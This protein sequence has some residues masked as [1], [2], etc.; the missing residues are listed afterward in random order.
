MS[1]K[2]EEIVEKLK[3]LTLLEASELVK[4]IEE[5]F[6]VDAS[7]SAA[8]TNFSAVNSGV[9][10]EENVPEEKT[11]FD[12]IIN[13]VPASKRITVIKVVRSLTSLGLKEA[14]DLIESVPKPIFESVPKEKAE[15]VKKLLEDAGASIIVK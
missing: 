1:T 5:T 12:V 15:E 7:I 14:K 13:E 8:P 3:S 4:R 11:E 2:I 9:K 10:P 6:G